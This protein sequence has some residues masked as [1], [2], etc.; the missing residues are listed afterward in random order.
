MTCEGDCA[1][2]WVYVS[3]QGARSS[4]SIYTQPAMP[5]LEK[6]KITVIR[7]PLGSET[8]EP[9][10]RY[11][12][13]LYPIRWYFQLVGKLFPRKAAQRAYRLLTTPMRRARHRQSDAILEQAR[14][15]E[16]MYGKELLKA[17][18]WGQGEQTVLLVHGWESRGTGLRNFVPGLV[19]EG[20]R[21][22]A[23]DGPAH[24][25]SGGRR[26]NLWHFA[27]AIRAILRR[28]GPVHAIVAHSFG[29]VATGYAL[30]WLLPQ[31][32]L[33]RLVL[34]GVPAH[35][36]AM[37]DEVRRMLHLNPRVIDALARIIEEKLQRPLREAELIH[38]W[39]HL[40]VARVLVVHDRYDKIV[41]FDSA[42]R[43]YDEWP[44]TELLITE[45]MGHYKLMKNAEVVQRVVRFI[46]DSEER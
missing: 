27:G 12:L 31:M 22:V 39:P 37:V 17:Y 24:G 3:I 20:Y 11:P 8:S 16:F 28:T 6:G 4:P 33:P 38:L 23:F 32:S 46:A 5:T 35:H 1:S 13:L 30:A 29:G 14:I 40:R 42:R 26:T 21:V 19:A 18:E 15:F 25:D 9:E 36:A 45:H 10:R 34:I 44:G 2:P 41:P 7:A 43:L